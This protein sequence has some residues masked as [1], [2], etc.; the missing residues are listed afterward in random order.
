V[1]GRVLHPVEVA[2]GDEDDLLGKRDLP[3][4]G[5]THER[6]VHRRV[7]AVRTFLRHCERGA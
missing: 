1:R 3:Q 2:A 7:A 6:Q 5:L 4:L